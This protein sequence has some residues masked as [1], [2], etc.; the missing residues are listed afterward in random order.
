M[1]ASHS[2]LNPASRTKTPSAAPAGDLQTLEALRNGDE[3]AFSALVDRHS[4][5][6]LRFVSLYVRDRSVAQEVVQDAWLGFLQSL[7][8][9]EGRSSLKTWLFRIAFNCAQKRVAS[10]G[11]SVPFSAL[12][13]QDDSAGEP[14]VDPDRFLEPDHRW[15]HHWRSPP[16]SWDGLPEARLLSNETLGLV[17]DSIAGLP[18]QQRDVITLRDVHGWTAA[19]VCNVLGLTETNQRVLLHRARSRVRR[20]LE[21]YLSGS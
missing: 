20:D 5:A 1:C 12:A 15:G 18:P 16:Q 21:R 11:R 9:F 17:R 14:S 10:E 8:R 13:H 6:V 19:E 2:A 4:A 3:Q 7:D